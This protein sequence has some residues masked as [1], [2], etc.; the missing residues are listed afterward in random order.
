VVEVYCSGAIENYIKLRS[1]KTLQPIKN[2]TTGNPNNFDWLSPK[3][4]EEKSD[5]EKA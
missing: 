5:E 3:I 1:I 4:Y 2:P